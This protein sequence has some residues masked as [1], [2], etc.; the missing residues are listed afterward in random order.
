[1]LDWVYQYPFSGSNLPSGRRSWDKLVE[2]FE[3]DPIFLENKDVFCQIIADGLNTI[4]ANKYE[5]LRIQMSWDVHPVYVEIKEKRGYISVRDVVTRKDVGFDAMNEQIALYVSIINAVRIV[6][7][8][9][10]QKPFEY[11]KE[12][13]YGKIEAVL[14]EDFENFIKGLE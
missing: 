14:T 10:Y 11:D 7:G 9:T 3:S 13:L 12:D 2:L 4:L 8:K 5:R 6:G 1:M